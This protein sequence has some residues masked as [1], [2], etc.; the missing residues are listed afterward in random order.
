[1]N[2]VGIESCVNKGSDLW[3]TW[4]ITAELV[5]RL[6]VKFNLPINRVMGHH[7][8]SAKDC[9]QPMLENNLEI[10]WEFL[11]LVEAEY[12]RITTYDGYT[13]T[14]EVINGNSDAFGRVTQDN[15]FN[16]ITYK[17][18]ITSKTG[19]KEEVTLSSIIEGSWAN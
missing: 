14:M 9:P 6:M 11:S 3:K 8:F 5:A 13:F 10:W 7:F 19:Q 12:E 17:V 15:E 16:L 1:M 18:T 4:Q 2:S